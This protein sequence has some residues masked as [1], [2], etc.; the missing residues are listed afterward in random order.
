MS[1]ESS[2][3]TAAWEGGGDATVQM[4]LVVAMPEVVPWPIS[5]PLMARMMSSVQCT[6]S[7]GNVS[8]GDH[9]GTEGVLLCK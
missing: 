3:N 4:Q 9:K 2:G 6:L 5:S 8:G 1:A 7:H